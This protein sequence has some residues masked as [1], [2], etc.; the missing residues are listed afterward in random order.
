[1]ILFT[2]EYKP[3]HFYRF[4]AQEQIDEYGTKRYF[5]NSRL[6]FTYTE[7]TSIEHWYLLETLLGNNPVDWES[8]FTIYGFGYP[9]QPLKESFVALMLLKQNALLKTMDILEVAPKRS[10]LSIPETVKRIIEFAD[11]PWYGRLYDTIA[12]VE[13]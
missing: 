10:H 8:T 6:F 5:L 3:G 12:G 13:L 9:P 1:M 2:W 11:K 7:Y 4:P